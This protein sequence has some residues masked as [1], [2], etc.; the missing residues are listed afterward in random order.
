MLSVKHHEVMMMEN[1]PTVVYLYKARAK[2]ELRNLWE[3]FRVL[4]LAIKI[5]LL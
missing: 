3:V 1:F 4:H 5:F 2:A